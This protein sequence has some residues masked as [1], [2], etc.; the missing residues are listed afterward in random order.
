MPRKDYLCRQRSGFILY[1]DPEKKVG[2]PSRE[3]GAW[4]EAG[5][6]DPEQANLQPK[7]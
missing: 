3:I 2:V 1:R 7:P 4:E 6:R 5:L